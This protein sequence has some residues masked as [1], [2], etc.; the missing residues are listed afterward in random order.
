MIFLDNLIIFCVKLDDVF[1]SILEVSP[2]ATEALWEM[3]V[4]LKFSLLTETL[5]HTVRPS[6][7]LWRRS[8]CPVDAGDVDSL[9]READSHLRCMP[10]R[11][12]PSQVSLPRIREPFSWFL[13]KTT[14]LYSV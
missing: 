4:R 8:K 3:T 12:A 14:S 2:L 10:R 1:S 9:L 13:H 7:L 6:S 5:V 11:N